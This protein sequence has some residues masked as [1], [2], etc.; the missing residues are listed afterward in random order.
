MSCCQWG[1]RERKAHKTV[2]NTY[3]FMNTKA[4]EAKIQVPNHHKKKMALCLGLN[5]EMEAS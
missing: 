5:T 4:Q 3:H 2:L 1:G